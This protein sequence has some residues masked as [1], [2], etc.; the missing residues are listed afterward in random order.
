MGASAGIYLEPLG[1]HTP[2]S[3]QPES[4]AHRA[5]AGGAGAGG[6][7]IGGS[8]ALPLLPVTHAL[9]SP[10]GTATGGWS[11]APCI[12]QPV[13]LLGCTVQVQQPSCAAHAVQQ[14]S[15]VGTSPCTSGRC[16]L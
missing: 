11:V 15:G 1:S 12:Q 6:G 14:A 5:G 13:S 10:H 4:V 9:P 2:L 16:Q 3:E 8:G 7:A